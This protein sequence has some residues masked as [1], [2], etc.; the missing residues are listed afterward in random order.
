MMTTKC[1]CSWGNYVKRLLHGPGV[2]FLVMSACGLLVHG[3]VHESNV[4]GQNMTPTLTLGYTAPLALADFGTEPSSILGSLSPTVIVLNKTFVEGSPS[5][6]SCLEWQNEPLYSPEMT[7]NSY[8]PRDTM[9]AICI[10][11]CTNQPLSSIRFP[12]VFTFP[13]F[14]GAQTPLLLSITSPNFIALW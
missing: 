7:L 5:P 4:G 3:W 2:G 14:P 13:Q 8:Q 1:L 10:T 11:S 6:L 12:P 9:T